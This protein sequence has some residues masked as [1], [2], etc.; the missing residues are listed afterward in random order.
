MELKGNSVLV[1][2]IGKKSGKRYV[3]IK[4]TLPSG[5]TKVIF[6]DND[7]EKYLFEMNLEKGV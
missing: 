1:D 7:A 4:V 6:P 2:G 5:Y 3:A